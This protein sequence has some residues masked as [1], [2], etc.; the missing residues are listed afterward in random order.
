MLFA[1]RPQQNSLPP[2][3]IPRPS[4][5]LPPNIYHYFP[6]LPPVFSPPNNS[7]SSSNSFNILLQNLIVK[8]TIENS[9]STL[10]I[11]QEFKNNDISPIECEYRFP[12]PPE[13]IVTDINILL[14]DGSKLKSH[15]KKE[16]KAKEIYQDALSQGNSAYLAKQEDSTTMS[17]HIGNIGPLQSL[18]IEIII[19]FPLIVENNS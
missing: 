5:N 3:I 13:A 4:S 15:I 11:N 16:D 19:V 9:L 17:I 12:I 8:S 1:I 14:P 2:P 7:T 18:R 10:I 6:N